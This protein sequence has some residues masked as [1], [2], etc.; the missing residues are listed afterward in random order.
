M[1]SVPR[2]TTLIAV[3]VALLIAAGAADAKQTPE[4]KCQKGRSDAA[5]KYAACQQKAMGKLYGGGEYEKFQKA[6][7]KC[8][9]KYTATWP[10]LQKKASGTGATCDHARFV[11]NGATVPDNL[12]GL[13]WE[14]KTDDAGVYD[15][16]NSCTWSTSA[17]GDSG[18]GDGTAFTTCLAALNSG[19]CFAEQCD[20]RLP[21]LAKLQT[22]L[23][24]GW[25]C[26][27]QPCSDTVLGVTVSSA[28]GSSTARAGNPDGV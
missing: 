18:D 8:A 26:S 19:A 25:P 9:V 20:S 17:D 4:Q 12:T 1:T 28:Y 11:D 27:T 2:L 16:D 10:R 6:I 24:A 5:A 3:A 7:G 23:L 22:L 13:Q 14:E 15:K 21:T